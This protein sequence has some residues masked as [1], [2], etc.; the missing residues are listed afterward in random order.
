MKINGLR[1]P[2]NQF[3]V[4]PDNGEV[5]GQ[6]MATEFIIGVKDDKVFYT[7]INY[8]DELFFGPLVYGDK[9]PK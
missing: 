7:G 1:G 8:R 2:E 4:R 9:L 6:L 5:T 3:F